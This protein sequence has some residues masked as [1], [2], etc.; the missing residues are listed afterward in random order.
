[1]QVTSLV[2]LTHPPQTGMT[3]HRYPHQ[4]GRVRVPLSGSFFAKKGVDQ[5]SDI[6]TQ[7]IGNAWQPERAILVVH[8][9]R[10]ST[11]PIGAP[12]SFSL[13]RQFDLV[14]LLDAFSP[15]AERVVRV[16]GLL[17]GTGLLPDVAEPRPAF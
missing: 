7:A 8:P 13:K 12:S 16:E 17:K 3:R 1:M 9:Q 10:S 5:P 6:L 4:A 15:L 11:P 14:E 2:V